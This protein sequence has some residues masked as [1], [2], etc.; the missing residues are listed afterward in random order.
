MEGAYGYRHAGYIEKLSFK[1]DTSLIFDFI[2]DSE[3]ISTNCSYY[4]KQDSIFISAA[5]EQ[6]HVKHL[7]ISDTF[8]M[9][10][11]K[12]IIH[13]STGNRY[14]KIGGFVSMSR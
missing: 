8:L 2:N 10:D 7:T 12:G 13:V 1:S 3:I 14:G 6:D 5:Q 11:K 4:I 9:I